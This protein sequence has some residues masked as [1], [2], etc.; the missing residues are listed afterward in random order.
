MKISPNEERSLR[1]T[2]KPRMQASKLARQCLV[3]PRIGHMDA[4]T[5][6]LFFLGNGVEASRPIVWII[7]FFAFLNVYSVQAVLPMVMDDFHTTALEAG[8]TVGATV[9]AIGLVSPF[10]GMLSDAVGR[11]VVLCTSMFALTVPTALIPISH[12]LDTLIVLRF[13][14]GLTIP[15]IAVV[16]IAYLSEEFRSGGVVQMTA[17]YVGGTVM[18][19]FCGRF[20][21]GHAGHLLGWRGAFVTLAV[22]NLLGALLVLWLL[23]PSRRFV[24]NR[25]VTGGMQ[26]LLLHLRNRRLMAACAVGFCVLFSLVGTFTYVNLHLALA[27]F[28]LSAAGLANVFTVYL[29][30]VIVTPLA[31]RHID[32]LGFMKSL[33]GALAIS[34]TG[35]LLTLLPSIFFVVVGLAVCSTGVF[36]CQSA[37]IGSIARTVSEGRSLATG[38]YYL[39]YYC[40]G[41]AGSWLAGLAFEGW[42]WSGSV[43]TIALFQGIAAT[44]VLSV[45]R[46]RGAEAIRN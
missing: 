8:M 3:A 15:G 20:L 41:A 43:A 12:S 2:S 36:L 29:V 14:Q 42:G 31:G 25:N 1:L 21:T 7:G 6:R 22:L 40:G 37:T 34:A 18:G 23:P 35:L 17:T 10:I 24:P 26:T 27:P 44:I 46:E 28:N 33:L 13:L 9:L 30:G 4:R 45:W 32:R 39:S 5:V 38:I 16:L 19:G 11:K